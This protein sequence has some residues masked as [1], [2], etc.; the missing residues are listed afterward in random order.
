M[1]R[2]HFLKLSTT[3]IAITPWLTACS[4]DPKEILATPQTLGTFC[5]RE[6]LI[7]IGK[8]YRNAQP[9]ED[10]QAALEE[11]L[12]D[13]GGVPFAITDSSSL[14]NF[15]NEKITHEFAHDKLAVVN[16]W[17]LSR[18]EVRQVALYSLLS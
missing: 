16:G 11:L 10:S 13:D 2:R 15:L 12:L 9:D 3:A 6:E 4:S 8:T 17:V 1:R 5:S 18:T 14:V 7:L